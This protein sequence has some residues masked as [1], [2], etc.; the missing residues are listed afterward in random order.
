MSNKRTYLHP[1]LEALEVLLEGELAFNAS[2]QG[3]ETGEG[4]WDDDD[5]GNS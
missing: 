1:D 4:S 2:G 3:S 5:E